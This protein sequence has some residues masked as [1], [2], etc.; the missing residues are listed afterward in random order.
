M[1]RLR[2]P[3][4]R[5]VHNSAQVPILDHDRLN[6]EQEEQ[7]TTPLISVPP[8]RSIF[9]RAEAQ[10]QPAPGCTVC[11][12][13][14]WC[15]GLRSF[16]EFRF[17]LFFEGSWI[18][19]YVFFSGVY[20]CIFFDFFSNIKLLC[21]VNVEYLILI[22]YRNTFMFIYCFNIIFDIETII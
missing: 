9:D 8:R 14:I 19:L 20:K 15:F 22:L 16:G 6:G 3:G 18:F 21:N 12:W 2:G 17:F 1:R 4:A 10:I 11:S 7:K 5:R 13:C